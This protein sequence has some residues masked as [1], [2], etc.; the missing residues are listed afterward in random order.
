MVNGERPDCLLADTVVSGSKRRSQSGSAATKKD[1][2]LA[3]GAA[4]PE[5]VPR[6]TCFAII[7]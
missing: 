4:P 2:E 1:G 5:Q 3:G 7:F 6:H